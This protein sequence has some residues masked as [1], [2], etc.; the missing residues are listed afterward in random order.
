MM[1]FLHSQIVL[2]RPLKVPN[3][4]INGNDICTVRLAPGSGCHALPASLSTS[5]NYLPSRR[6]PSF[7]RRQSNLNNR[8]CAIA[9]YGY[10]RSCLLGMAAFRCFSTISSYSRWPNLVLPVL[11][12]VSKFVTLYE[13]LTKSI[14]GKRTMF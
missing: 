10:D 7:A 5:S 3:Y 2:F 1:C 11:I 8:K 14:T 12:V 9:L 4:C 13:V 6:L